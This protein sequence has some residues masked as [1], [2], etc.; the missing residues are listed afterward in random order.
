MDSQTLYIILFVVM[1]VFFMITG[2]W[3]AVVLGLMGIIF[4]Y[5]FVGSQSLG[6]LGYTV[7]NA[8]HDYSMAAIPLFI[9]MATILSS[10][11]IGSRLFSGTAALFS[12][13]P[14]GLLHANIMASAGF[15]SVCGS[16]MATCACIS[17]VSVPVMEKE[18]YPENL[19]LGSLIAA[20]GLG[21]MIPPSTGFIMYGALCGVS[22]GKLF[23]AGVF[24]GILIAILFSA[25]IAIRCTITDYHIP[26]YKMNFVNTVKALSSIWPVVVLFLSLMGAIF[27]GICTPTEASGLGV[28][29][30]LIVAF[31]LKKINKTMLKEAFVEATKITGMIYLIFG[32]AIVLTHSLSYLGVPQHLAASLVAL[33]FPKIGVLAVVSVLY[34]ILGCVM[35]A[36]SVMV[37]TLPIIYPIVVAAGIDP[38][39]FGVIFM[40]YCEMAAITPPVGINLFVLQS[41]TKKPIDKVARG[42]LPFFLIYCGII[43]ILYIF[44]QIVLYLP[45]RM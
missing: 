14:G 27:Y 45:G 39:W 4:F 3:I 18:R 23:M 36:T 34:I 28:S 15:A 29:F 6:S 1:I 9:F 42:V 38:I 2:V 33:H 40:V 25:Y 7:Y 31:I 37:C 19:A 5:F 26:Q 30:A 22:I 41:I 11:G 20:G 10:S 43:V 35:D 21:V 13:L 16:T 24:P 17:Q 44:P 12:R 8:W 32:F